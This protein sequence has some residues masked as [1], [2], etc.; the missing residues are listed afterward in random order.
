[1]IIAILEFSHGD[2]DGYTT[3]AFPFK[4]EESMGEFLQMVG[5]FMSYN[6]RPARVAS[7]IERFPSL[8]E[9][10]PIQ[11]RDIIRFDGENRSPADY[12]TF[13]RLIGYYDA[14]G[15]FVSNQMNYDINGNENP[16]ILAELS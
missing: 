4:N 8:G 15:K 5:C 10:Y 1:M 12:A 6:E 7:V 9:I 13:E 16:V 11:A 14:S 2:C 3:H